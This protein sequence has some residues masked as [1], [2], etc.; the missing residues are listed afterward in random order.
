MTTEE[1]AEPQKFETKKFV[2]IVVAALIFLFFQFVCPVPAGLERTAMSAVGILVAC[3]VL[4]VTEAM[5][6]IVTVV[7]IF[8]LIPVTGI[9]PYSTTTTESGTVIQSVFN[10]SSLLVPIYCLFVFTV[11][12][13]VMSTPIPYRV[14]NFALKWAGANSRKLIIGFSLA[15]SVMSMFVSDLAAS[16]IFIGIGIS[17]VEA[18]GG[19]KGQSGLAKALT[20]AI[21]AA[22]AIGG[23]GT[24]IGNSL[25]I[26][27]MTM[28]ETYMGV[29]VSFLAW[30]VTNIPLALVTSLL[31]GLYV[32]K[33]FKVEEISPEAL[34]VV[35]KKL[36]AYDKM[37]SKEIKLIIWFVIAFGLM[38]ASTWI[39]SINSMLVAF[40]FTVIAFIPGI[41]LVTKEQF[42]ASIPWEIIMMIIGVQAL[43]TGLVGTGVATWFVNT[44]L[45][46][47]ESWPPILI[48]LVM[49]VITMILHIAI[50]V[51]PPT[52]SVAVPL[53]IALV[54][55]VN[56]A[57]GAIV[58][59]PAV[60]ACIGG[61]LG[62]VTTWLPIDS[63]MMIC[64][65][66]GWISM[67]EWVSRAWVSTVILLVLTVFWTPFI[68]GIIV[69]A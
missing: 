65:E 2:S 41:N 32:S 69:P 26:L 7:L 54:S 20:I 23:I 55:A 6:F 46:G 45:A 42:H 5:P 66:K 13:A 1:I 25:N 8:F 22:A 37:T 39:T 15:T 11:S 63:I 27:C 49:C 40:A 28:V 62:G 16:A 10:Q 9:L 35:E 34:K 57:N 59:N 12:G 56:T 14:A 17:I 48:V 38:I 18:N 67:N 31:S 24:P 33:V 29:R 50:P 30:C 68:C 19:V 3:I 60:I 64:Y 53:M 52:V 43:A 51:G 61:I 21:A 36:V 58:I 44:L 47:A 4:W